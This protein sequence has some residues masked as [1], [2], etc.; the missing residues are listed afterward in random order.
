MRQSN[1]SARLAAGERKARNGFSHLEH[2][3]PEAKFGLVAIVLAELLHK[4]AEQRPLFRFVHRLTVRQ[5]KLMND[6]RA[7]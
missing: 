3:K 7:D 5:I 6:R 1:K 2:L 4:R